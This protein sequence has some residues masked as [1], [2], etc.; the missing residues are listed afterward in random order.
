VITLCREEAMSRTLKI[1]V[2]D[3]ERDL[4]DY[5]QKKLSRLGHQVVAAADGQQL[6]ALCREFGPDV[7]VT[8]LQMPGLDGL[9]AAAAVNRERAVPVILLSAQHGVERLAGA[10][11]GCLLVCLPKPVYFAELWAAIDRVT[12]QVG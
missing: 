10:R 3:D 4:R 5:L 8:D 11:G 7:I 1:A 9:A 12:A 2:A 6:L